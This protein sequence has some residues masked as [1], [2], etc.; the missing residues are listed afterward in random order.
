MPDQWS[1]V[2]KPTHRYR[3]PAFGSDVKQHQIPIFGHIGG[4]VTTPGPGRYDNTKD[5]DKI[6][7]PLTMPAKE[8]V[9]GSQ[10]RSPRHFPRS[11]C[12]CM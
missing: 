11:K 7:K 2:G 12:V 1:K 4:G 9:F 8:T 5:V 3:S 10:V 6:F